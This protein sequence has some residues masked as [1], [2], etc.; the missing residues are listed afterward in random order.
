MWVQ[1]GAR[2]EEVGRAVRPGADGGRASAWR[3]GA[4]SEG[5]IGCNIE[6][7]QSID[8]PLQYSQES[9]IAKLKNTVPT[10][11]QEGGVSPERRCGLHFIGPLPCVRRKPRGVRRRPPL[12]PIRAG[13]GNAKQRSLFSHSIPSQ[14]PSAETSPANVKATTIQDHGPSLGLR[15]QPEAG[16]GLRASARERSAA[17]AETGGRAPSAPRARGG[18]LERMRLPT[19]PA[20]QQGQADP[21]RG[22]NG[23]SSHSPAREP[24]SSAEPPLRHSPPLMPSAASTNRR[25]SR[26]YI[27]RPSALRGA[28]RQIVSRQ[29]ALASGCDCALPLV[30]VEARCI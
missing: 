15:R 3:R 24:S 26:S 7:K 12:V 20:S 6:R 21:Y 25:G 22:R 1:V 13:A 28:T 9:P 29:T 23:G 11:W 17:R 4:G 19:R 27:Q 5:A 30:H 18:S 14:H 2:A 16:R 8:N 10:V